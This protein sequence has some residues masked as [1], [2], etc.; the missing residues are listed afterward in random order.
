MDRAQFFWR[1]HVGLALVAHNLVGDAEFFEQ[2]QHALRAGIVEMM[3]GQHWCPPDDAAHSRGGWS[4]QWRGEKSRCPAGP[5]PPGLWTSIIYPGITNLGREPAV[6]GGA[7]VG[8][9]G[10]RRHGFRGTQ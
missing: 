4:C 3:N 6:V 1:T 10:S 9:G 7:L 5:F 2:P 8:V